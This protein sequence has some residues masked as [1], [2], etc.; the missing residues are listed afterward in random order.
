MWQISWK[1]NLLSDPVV[2]CVV[3]WDL[4]GVFHVPGVL[5]QTLFNLLLQLTINH[6]SGYPPSIAALMPVFPPS[7]VVL[8]AFVV[9]WVSD[10]SAKAINFLLILDRTFKNKADSKGR[11]RNTPPEAIHILLGIVLSD[12]E[13]LDMVLIKDCL[14]YNWHDLVRVAV[15]LDLNPVVPGQFLEV[16]GSKLREAVNQALSSLL[17]N[18]FPALNFIK[19]NPLRGT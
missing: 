17:S 9:I 14:A 8:E 5:E 16:E 19:V 4:R 7:T 12:L 13:C 15:V 18:Y 6:L 1:V 10:K 3:S 11:Y 2:D